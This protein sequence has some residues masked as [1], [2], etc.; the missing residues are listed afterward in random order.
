M[1]QEDNHRGTL[2][3]AVV[4]AVLVL[5]T[6]PAWCPQQ[7]LLQTMD[8]AR[9]RPYLESSRDE[10][11]G[12]LA[13]HRA[14]KAVRDLDALAGTLEE[15]ARRN[16]IPPELVLAVIGAESSF[17]PDAVSRKGAV[18]LMQLMP[19]TAQQLASELR[20]D[21]T[22]EGLLLDP[23]ANI[24]M[25]SRYLGQLLTS[26][27]DLDHTLAAYN[28]GPRAVRV[29]GWPRGRGETAGFVRRVKHLL[30]REGALGHSRSF[31]E[32]R[33]YRGT[34]VSGL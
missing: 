4:A 2:R 1:R 32:P 34:G 25:G 24:A 11:A 26:F 33:F 14:R 8:E 19:Y 20:M 3:R 17:R 31:G 13:R 9:L 5:A 16:S 12:L 23:H 22:G 10:I 7:S 28:R 18:G 30:S 6:T 15:V 21:W 27:D 29:A